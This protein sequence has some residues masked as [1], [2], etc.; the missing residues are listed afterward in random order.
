MNE[1]KAKT[2]QGVKWNALGK[3]LTQGVNFIVGLLLAR[4]L[5]PSDYGVVGMIGVFF[6]IAQTFI[7]SG[8][9]SALIRK[10]VCSESDLSTAFY[11]NIIIGLVCFAILI[12]SAPWVAVFLKTPILKDIVRVMSL[13][14]LIGSFGIVHGAKLTR[15]ID[16]KSQTKIG[17]VSSVTSGTIGV[18]MA[19]YGCGVWSLVVQ[20]LLATIVRVSGLW[21]VA[22]W[23]PCNHFSKESFRYLYNYGSKILASNLLHTLYCNMTTLLIG[24]LYSAKDLGY[25]NRGESLASFTNTNITSVIQNVSFPVLSKMQGTESL[26]IASYRKLISVSSIVVF[27]VMC[28]L[29]V[30]AKPLV[31]TL[32]T[33]KWLES[34]VYLQIFCIAYMFDHIC[35]LNLNLLY[36]KG[37]SDLVLRLEI[38]KKTISISMILF[39]V[40]YGVIAICISRAIYAQIAVLINTY[41]SGK[42]F[43][44]S[45]IKQFKDFGKYLLLSLI[46]VIPSCFIVITELSGPLQLILGCCSACVIYGFLLRKDMYF[47]ELLQLIKV[48]HNR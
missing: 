30:L 33:D 47:Y 17:L 29:M 9:G 44:L 21:F 24:K 14:M 26:L 3:F 5:N 6:A 38:V 20:T 2:I 10:E 15:E 4:L 32:L 35:Y 41:Y 39:A 22:K 31:I 19:Y 36:V 1:L 16:F 48:G 25:Y 45:Y 27:F 40:Q 11:F 18:L 7:E 46:S 12:V 28:L 23:I 42:L 34:V 8:F 13:N 37:C 43:G